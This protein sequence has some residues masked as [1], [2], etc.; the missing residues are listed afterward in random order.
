MISSNLSLLHT[1][2]HFQDLLKAG[3][4]R[5]WTKCLVPLEAFTLEGQG[6]KLGEQAALELDSQI[7]C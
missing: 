6:F 2:G 7:P 4:S 5:V 1:Y 3:Q